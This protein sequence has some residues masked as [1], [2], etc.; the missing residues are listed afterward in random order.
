MEGGRAV[1]A[2][3]ERGDRSKLEGSG[4]GGHGGRGR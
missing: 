3:W 2:D 1:E 4:G